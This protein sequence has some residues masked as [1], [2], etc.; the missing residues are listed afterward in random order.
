M[1]VFYTDLTQ[2][3]KS[4]LARF[5]SPMTIIYYYFCFTWQYIIQSEKI[6]CVFIDSEAYETE[7]KGWRN[8]VLVFF[9]QKVRT[10]VERV[11][12]GNDKLAT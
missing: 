12:T 5:S 11:N 8:I 9:W 10:S 6:K 7:P 2:H 4:D 1:A 3:T